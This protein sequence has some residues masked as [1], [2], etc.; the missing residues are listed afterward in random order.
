MSKAVTEKINNLT[1]EEARSVVSKGDRAI[2]AILD[3]F[4]D[5]SEHVEPPK[6]EPVFEIPD[7]LK[8]MPDFVEKLLASVRAKAQQPKPGLS[9]EQIRAVQEKI[10]AESIEKYNA[11]A[12]HSEAWHEADR[13]NRSADN[14]FPF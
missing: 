13:A 6:P 9:D 7:F 10:R 14:D 5:R 12:G 3:E 11:A 4:V 2:D 8:G 1:V